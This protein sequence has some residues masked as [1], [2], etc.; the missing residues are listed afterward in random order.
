MVTITRGM[1]SMEHKMR[2]KV[3]EIFLFLCINF[4]ICAI[5]VQLDKVAKGMEKWSEVFAE[6]M[7]VEN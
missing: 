5:P 7:Y 3:P 6:I 2:N 1:L 4:I